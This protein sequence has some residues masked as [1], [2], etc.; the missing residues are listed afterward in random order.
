MEYQVS[1][2][3]KKDLE[4]V[5][6]TFIDK[7]QMPLWEKGLL[8]VES[9]KGELFLTG[10]EGYLVFEA[11]EHHQKMKVTTKLNE[12]PYKIDLIY[13]VPGAWNLCQNTFTE[14]DDET[15]WTMDVEFKFDQPNDY[16]KD[17]FINQ[18][19]AGMMLFKAYLEKSNDEKN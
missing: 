14:K 9:I 4:T 7:Q 13:E 18:T 8:H 16:P 2:S 19:L 12:L 11:G 5:S 6:D 10:S 1:V 3:I 17:L 15:I